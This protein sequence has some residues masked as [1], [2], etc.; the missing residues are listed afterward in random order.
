MGNKTVIAVLE[1]AVRSAL[2][3]AANERIKDHKRMFEIEMSEVRRKLVNDI[4]NTIQIQ[5]AENL[6]TGEYV[7]QIKLNGGN[8]NG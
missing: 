6:P 8:H 2:Y 4:V 1:E 3:E 5:A 7:I